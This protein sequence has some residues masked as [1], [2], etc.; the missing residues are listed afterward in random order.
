MNNRRM[1]SLLLALVM[2]LSL[3]PTSTLAK[4]ENAGVYSSGDPVKL[5]YNIT[6]NAL[7]MSK[8]PVATV[9]GYEANGK[10]T[11]T[12]LD[13]MDLADWKK[14]YSVDAEGNP[15]EPYKIMDL[16]KT[17]PFAVEYPNEQFADNGNRVCYGSDNWSIGSDGIYSGF[18]KVRYADSYASVRSHVTIRVNVPYA[19]DYMLAGRGPKA[20]GGANTT[21]I[22]TPAPANELV[23]NDW[24]K[25]FDTVFAGNTT[26]GSFSCATQ[27]GVDKTTYTDIGMVR[28]PTAGEYLVTFHMPEK[29]ENTSGREPFYLSGLKLTPIVEQREL[30]YH[31][32]FDVLSTNLYK[33]SAP[34]EGKN[35]LTIDGLRDASGGI[36]YNQSM[37]GY[38]ATVTKDA[39]GNTVEPFNVINQTKTDDW[40]WA[41][42]YTPGT[43]GIEAKRNAMNQ[44]YAVASYGSFSSG[45]F[46]MLRVNVPAAGK[47]T[48]S[49]NGTRV[50]GAA[51]PAV[52][53]FQDDGSK[54]SNREDGYNLFKTKTPIGYADF[55]DTEKQGYVN[56]GTAEVTSA[57]DYFIVLFPDQ[58]S[59]EISPA[60][61]AY[62][63]ILLTDLKLAPFKE[64][65]DVDT[66]QKIE[67]SADETLIE[68]GKT[69]QIT[70]L[71]KY[72]LSGV[73]EITDGITYESSNDDIATVSDEGVVTGV[74]EG[75]V[76][77]TAAVGNV[78][79]TIDIEVMT[80]DEGNAGVMLEYRTTWDALSGDKLPLT[81]D[82]D[83][84][85]Y[86]TYVRNVGAG[87]IVNTSI[88]NRLA[89]A[90]IDKDEQTVPE[91][92]IMNF[93]ITDPWDV[94]FEKS[95]GGIRIQKSTNDLFLNYPIDGYGN[96]S[97]GTFMALRLN[98]PHKGTYRLMFDTNAVPHGVASAIYFIRDNGTVTGVNDMY[99]LIASNEPVTYFDFSEKFEG[100]KKACELEVPRAGEYFIVFFGGSESLSIN[101]TTTSDS[102]Y[103][104]IYL[105]GIRL[106][107]KPGKLAK[108]KASVKGISEGDPMALYTKRNIVCEMMDENDVPIDEI[109]ETKL[110]VEYKSRDERIASVSDSGE[111]EALS[112][113]NTIIEVKITYDGTSVTKELPILVAPAGKNLMADKNPDFESDLWVWNWPRQDELVGEPKFMRLAIENAPTEKN[114]EN[115]AMAVILDGKSIGG[116][117]DSI[118]LIPGKDRIKA[119]PG[120]FYELSFK[121]KV[122][123]E[124]PP[125]GEDLLVY[126]E[127]YTYSNPSGVTGADIPV[128]TGR[129]GEISQKA[130]WR[131][132][133]SEWVDVVLPVPGPTE[134]EGLEA[135]YITPR[136]G[137]RPRAG[138]NNRDGHT[139]KIW[140]DDFNLREVGYAG[141]EVSVE[142]KT[143]ASN[144]SGVFVKSKPYTSTGS[145]I[146]LGGTFE[147]SDVILSASDENVVSGFLNQTLD[148]TFAGSGHRISNATIQLGGKNGTSDIF[149][150]ITL[151]GITRTGKTTVETSGFD[152]KLLYA[153]A[154]G[155][156]GV[157]EAGEK[158][159][160]VPIGY[161]SD[162]SLA[163]MTKV[164]VTYK[165][166]TPDILSVDKESGEVTALAAGK[167][168]IEVN[169]LL[170]NSGAQAIADI[171]V[172]DSSPIVSA[173]LS[174]CQTVGY[175]R[176]EKLSLSGVTEKGFVADMEAAAIEWIVECD[177]VG[178]VTINDDGYIFGEIF[179]ASAKV[180]AKVTLNGATV[181][182]N[183]ITVTVSETDLRD[184]S[185]DFRKASEKKPA[186]VRI[187]V[188]N[189]ELDLE[190]SQSSVASSTFDTRGLNGNT[191]SV[192]GEMV[193]RVNVPYTGYYQM[194]MHIGLDGYSATK[195]AIF[196][197]NMYIGTGDWAGMSQSIRENLRSVYLTAGEHEFIFRALE[198]GT[199]G[200]QQVIKELRFR[201]IDALPSLEKINTSENILL[202]VGEKASVG[203]SVTMSDGFTYAGEKAAD[204]SADELIS[205]AYES[206]DSGIASVS[207]NGELEAVSEGETEIIVKALSGKEELS[208]KIKVKVSAMAAE[209]NVL[210]SAEIIGKSFVMSTGSE[211]IQ[212][213][214]SGK[215]AAGK[216]LDTTAAEILWESTDTSVAS[217]SENGFVTPNGVGTTDITLTILLDG[218]EKSVTRTI[219]VRDGK[220]ARTYYTDEMVAAARE[221]TQK[222]KWAI[223]ELNSLTTAAERYLPIMDKLYEMIPGEGIPRAA[224]AAY[225]NDP[226]GWG[227]NYCGV[228]LYTEYDHYPWS[229]NPLSVPWK[230]QCPN[231]KRQ[232]PSN[233][234]EK[235][236]ELGRDEHGIY[237]RELAHKRNAELV[238]NGEQ[239]Y[240][241]NVLYPEIGT[242][243]HPETVK[244]TDGETTEGW[245]VDDG[246]GYN[247]GRKHSNGVAEVDTYIAYY[248]HYGVWY[249]G[250]LGDS[251][252][253]TKALDTLGR[254]YL[255]TGDIKYG[256][257]GAVMVDRIADV[258]PGFSVAQYYPSFANSDGNTKSGQLLGSIW[259]TYI[260]QDFAAAYD[261]F[262]PAYD[263]PEVVDFLA[264][265]AVKFNNAE[266]NDKTTPE[267][268]RRNIEDGIL[269]EIYNSV[270]TSQSNGNFGMHHNS[271][272]MAAVILDTHPDTDNMIDWVFRYGKT[273]YISY[274][275]GGGV[276]QKLV[277]TVTRDG[278]G[279]ESAFG[280]NRIWVTQL[281]GLANT[282][283]RYP[284]YEGM[285]L[286]EHPKYIGMIQS[287]PYMHLVRRGT[288]GI[289]DGGGAVVYNKLPDRDEVM[290]DS[291][292][293]LRNTNVEEAI[294]IA[295]HLY[296][297][298]DGELEEL[299]YDI[300]TK[301]PESLADEVD[302]IIEEHGEWNYDKSAMLTG[303]GMGIIRSGTLHKTV[304]ANVI[305]DTQRDFWMYFGG[306]NS[307]NQSDQLH[308]GIESYGIGM[309]TDLG[310]PEATGHDPNRAQW[311]NTTISHNAVV[312]NEQNQMR[313][314]YTH[315][316]LHY[317]AKD[318]RV[319]VM[320]IDA[321][322]AYTVTDEYRRSIVM[323]DYDSEVS[324]GIDFFKVRGG[325][326]HLYSFHAN[327]HND[328][329]TSDNLSFDVQNGGTYA[330][331]NVPFG[332]DPWTNVGNNYVPLKYPLGYTWLFD[333]KRADNPGTGEFF[334]D[335]SINDFRNHSRNGKLDMHLRMTAVNDWEAAEVTLANGMPPRTPDNLSVMNHLEYMLVRRKG[336]DL[337]TLFTT[338][339]EPYNGKRYIKS[340]ENVPVSVVSGTPGVH[341]VAKAVRV[342]FVDGRVDYVVYAQN[343]A[344]TYNVGDVFEFRG[345]V[346]VYTVNADGDNIYSYVNDGEK[347][348]DVENIDASLE[349]TIVDFQKE[350]S[351]YNWIDVKFDRQVTEEE[352]ASI[353]DRMI[354]VERKERGNSSFIII[355]AEKTGDDTARL[356][357]GGI[358]TIAGY[359]DDNNEEMGYRYDVAVGKSFEIPMSYEDNRAPVF[360][361][362]PEDIT[363]SAGNTIT[364][365]VNAEP[366]NAETVTYS[367]RTL[368]R[369]ATIDSETGVVSWQPTKSQ[370]GENL[371][372][373]DATD[374][375]GRT[376]TVYFSVTVYGSTSG[377]GG[378]GGSSGGG[379]GASGSAG[380]SGSSDSAGSGSSDTPSDG[381]DNVTDSTDSKDNTE[382][383][384]N[385][386]SETPSTEN[387]GATGNKEGFVDLD[388]HAWAEESIN[389]LADE[390]IIKGTSES[391]FSPAANITRA[392]F[393]ILLV[394]A[395][396]LESES[397]ENFADVDA[398][399]YFARELAIA[400][401][402][403]IVGGI[404]D[405]K[406]APRNT[407]TR[408]DMMVIVYRALGSLSL[409]GKVSAELTDEVLSQYPDFE[410]VAEYAR[411]AVRALISAGLVNGKSGKIA[412]TEYTTR[413]EVAVLLKRILDYIAK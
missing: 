404:G 358:T 205:F 90:V 15:C 341:D 12:I 165:S 361:D 207:E 56:I 386:E 408:Q 338:V 268:I 343:N 405:N 26:V 173:V 236:Y 319:K 187:E 16:T 135:I 388:S 242:A 123:Y 412:P 224:S 263:D 298:K 111:I 147:A 395:F 192:N 35:W 10:R 48:L 348:G 184:F 183:E 276:N 218:E 292:K 368:P 396:E 179:G 349:G 112:N 281:T 148:L 211:G 119:E 25:P 237:N 326:D 271:L 360:D 137:P 313:N 18:N 40:E 241:V 288:P 301:N 177:P 206:V 178:G 7:Y 39:S 190:K 243:N 23:D 406:Y 370:L 100:Y 55:S 17:D 365:Q 71:G 366:D 196:V 76:T 245:G 322:S 308:L 376:R 270:Q 347:I 11:D 332:N 335:Y 164:A 75:K 307:H 337:N 2:V 5:E 86:G 305:R 73:A 152:M 220:V 238:E 1:I 369:G 185:I 139:G 51:A 30:N 47:Y 283:A 329:T 227:C 275:T 390:G 384:K 172:T 410:S 285:S 314:I 89:T 43:F 181:E 34:P 101:P 9:G 153:E 247:T 282:L 353:A 240:L 44:N 321:S 133:Y 66:L 400:R 188:D 289:G 199:H 371:F 175:L 52:Y 78:S 344:V 391:T 204:G 121:M 208:R 378:S 174:E 120:R 259:E 8:L 61:G 125:N 62:Q 155:E 223:S 248:H 266:K 342:E 212:L 409:E 92:Q 91:W 232:F 254:A 149:S 381:K 330:G 351:F 200:A 392:D 331:A 315:Q 88:M 222:Y 354:N 291:F 94:A 363:A 210:A 37:M 118:Y 143:D 398:S 129:A 158:T 157:V 81:G 113:G 221:N 6:T 67:L 277:S 239:G 345:F 49:Y 251:G 229:V 296:F 228:N 50:E 246:F 334:I 250:G 171:T 97:S 320:D 63:E 339:I 399:D 325:E 84:Y 107:C 24:A 186:N 324:Y 385:T 167:G 109:D 323:I 367:G 252:I 127:Y 102:K 159:Q 13:N 373:I 375:L 193:M 98:V 312:V 27:N 122:D 356:D 168:K 58:N 79:A 235:L 383:D 138:D 255:Y 300:F 364:I 294:K 145:Y 60:S 279:N 20:E 68:A 394:R 195:Q 333:I 284:E 336:R 21:V 83:K 142:G 303:Y 4:E 95:P 262:F 310:Y 203:A 169:F 140:F 144:A 293:Y 317:D 32:A 130:G 295:Q 209:D 302:A 114:A 272:A 306:A 249:Q 256:R 14:T 117:P 316:P 225:R 214:A 379:A 269:R 359:A 413:A 72:S 350:L 31:V 198:K 304:E 134:V 28:I 202:T 110:S 346:G 401:N 22:I 29:P 226:D 290:L 372:G 357:L 80:L 407:I 299:H 352:V 69:A 53:F 387:G 197:D 176:D 309:T 141:V 230:I 42:D 273:D 217:I 3:L 253:I 328:P 82:S 74:S 85:T 99:K 362:I 87:L 261:A 33:Y 108:I 327:S 166:L 180:K 54:L 287:Y 403:G 297:L 93:D 170:D 162:G 382:T 38:N 161:M 374:E 19:G 397:T 244:F 355:G 280:Y 318:T 163:D 146:S 182:T 70:V 219:S 189:W 311:Q 36:L 132:E 265:K 154:Y 264:K 194:V 216:E 65:D 411:D 160:I 267:K 231:C 126:L 41:M 258:Y 46:L 393:A 380:G 59:L 201:A 213:E 191:T 257:I 96:T 233:D 103:Q 156:N 115:R 45:G 131:E 377:S 128:V 260:Q 124:N 234:F 151:N 215:S 402:T 340:I 116:T 389:A 278:Q 286:Y 150:E 105:E 274:N 77:I 104:H 106:Y 64:G 57:G 136:F